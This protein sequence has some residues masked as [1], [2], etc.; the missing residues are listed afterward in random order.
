MKKGVSSP[1]DYYYFGLIG[2]F[3]LF[4]GF[5]ILNLSTEFGL[6]NPAEGIG[7]S[8]TAVLDVYAKRDSIMLYLESVSKLALPDAIKDYYNKS[9]EFIPSNNRIG[10]YKDWSAEM[11]VV[12]NNIKDFEKFFKVAINKKYNNP[13]LSSLPDYEYSFSSNTYTELIAT[14]NNF[15][16]LPLVGGKG[17]VDYKVSD[18]R[19]ILDWP[20]DSYEIAS[21]F[22][23]RNLDSITNDFHDGID[24]SGASRSKIQVKT[25]G[26]GEVF[27]ICK[28]WSAANDCACHYFNKDDT[29]CIN[30]SKCLNTKCGG[31][32]NYIVIKHADN[33]FSKYSHLDAIN[34]N[35]KIGS[36]VNEGDFIGILGN[37]GRSSG[38]HLDLKIFTSMNDIKD[39]DKGKNPFCFFDQATLEKL[40]PR[41]NADSCKTTYEYNGQTVMNYNN[42]ALQEECAIDLVDSCVRGSFKN[43]DYEKSIAK[44]QNTQKNLDKYPNLKEFIEAE[45]EKR[46]IPPEYALAIVTQETRGDPTERSPTGPLG[47]WQ[48]SG[49]TAIKTMHMPGVVSCCNGAQS[50]SGICDKPEVFESRCGYT[51]TRLDP[52]VSTPYALDYLKKQIDNYKEYTDQL[53]FA[54]AHYNSGGGAWG[55][56]PGLIAGIAKCKVSEQTNDPGWDCVKSYVRDEGRNYGD[57]VIS[58]MLAWS[59]GIVKTDCGSTQVKEMGRLRFSPDFVFKTPDFVTPITTFTTKVK[60]MLK[61]DDNLRHNLQKQMLSGIPWK[62][63]IGFCDEG[64]KT[65]LNNII[66]Q[67]Q[68]CAINNQKNCDCNIDIDGELI[69]TP[70]TYTYTKNAQTVSIDSETFMLSKLDVNGRIIYTTNPFIDEV[71]FSEGEV[72]ID[73]VKQDY[74]YAKDSDGDLFLMPETEQKCLIT[75]QLFPICAEHAYGTVKLGIKLKDLIPPSQAS[76]LNANFDGSSI[77]LTFMSSSSPDILGYLITCNGGTPL[78]MKHENKRVQSFKLNDC[79]GVPFTPTISYK[80]GVFAIDSGANINYNQDSNVIQYSPAQELLSGLP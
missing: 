37:T 56:F 22:G 19:I 17:S 68:E 32:G 7:F 57:D 27:D 20:T 79:D 53:Y 5:A 24:I 9:F 73:G 66:L 50:R 26:S 2:F 42:P 52:F 28:E 70:G 75:E 25:V 55:N 45:A 48:I 63:K 6:H 78:L 64:L 80:L 18:N 16:N 29:D 30:P 39:K 35:L 71:K 21:C 15:V 38:P 11:P 54:A 4:S 47:L 34:N 1:T 59:G 74:V 69:I 40:T 33:L 8:Q 62:T 61:I 13:Y 43:I 60:N 10:S 44:I 36:Y 65:E 77:D 72:F 51:D 67:I 76:L 14:S 31:Y 49:P 46:G 12:D 23:Y 41:P 58:H 3:I